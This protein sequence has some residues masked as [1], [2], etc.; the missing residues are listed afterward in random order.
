MFTLKIGL[1]LAGLLSILSFIGCDNSNKNT[2]SAEQIAEDQKRFMHQVNLCFLNQYPEVEVFAKP[3]SIIAKDLRAQCLD[4]FSA[5]RAA[6]LNYAIVRDVIEPS[7]KMVQFEVEMAQIFI[8]SARSRA[9]L[10]FKEGSPKTKGHPP[11]T[12]PPIP[13]SDQPNEEPISAF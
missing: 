2:L 5:L 1:T 12:H 4:E 8:E 9:K 7:L 11:F 13:P 6:K 10:M 3:V